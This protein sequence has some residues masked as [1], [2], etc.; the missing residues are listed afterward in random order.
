M[1]RDAQTMSASHLSEEM[2]EAEEE[3]EADSSI[4]DAHNAAGHNGIPLEALEEGMGSM[5]AAP[6]SPRQASFR[7]ASPKPKPK[8]K[9]SISFPLSNGGPGASSRKEHGGQLQAVAGKVKDSARRCL[10]G[11][12]N[13]VF[14]QA[15]I[16]TFLGEWGDRSQIATIALAGAHVSALNQFAMGS[17]DRA[18][19]VGVIAFGTII[20]HGLCTAGAVMGGRYISTMI[21]VKHSTSGPLSHTLCCSSRDSS[22]PADRIQLL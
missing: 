7:A 8:P 18:Q 21:S 13:P 22:K 14:A 20:G 11:V 9:A 12:V 3:L 15:F 19:T 6:S 5:T 10:G 17:A 1:L 2:R 16:L 4:H